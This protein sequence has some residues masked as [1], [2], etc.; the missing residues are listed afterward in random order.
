MRGCGVCICGCGM[1]RAG[2]VEWTRMKVARGVSYKLAE[3]ERNSSLVRRVSLVLRI[4]SGR[5]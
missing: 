3:I 1:M 5:S 4:K 2:G